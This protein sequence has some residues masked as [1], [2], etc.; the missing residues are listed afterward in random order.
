MP[1]FDNGLPI[2][3]IVVRD[4]TEITEGNATGIGVADVTTQRVVRKMDWTKTYLNIVTAGVLDGGKLPI[5]AD[6]DRDAIGIG[7]RGCPGVASATAKMVRIKTTL[8]LTDVWACEPMLQ[9]IESNPRLEI[10]SDPV[11]CKFDN[12]GALMGA[13]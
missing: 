5:V 1:G 10:S 2:G 7:I 11:E 4:L 13:I 8:E 6:T 12:E 9:E 3:R